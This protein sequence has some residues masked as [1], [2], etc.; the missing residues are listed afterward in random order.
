[1]STVTRAPRLPGLLEAVVACAHCDAVLALL[2]GSLKTVAALA[3][4]RGWACDRGGW[5]WTCG[6]C[7]E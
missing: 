3:R 4:R 7:S 5:G 2:E 1:M 6:E